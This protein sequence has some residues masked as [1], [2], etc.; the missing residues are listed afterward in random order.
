MVP[1]EV[2]AGRP[3][4]QM[5]LNHQPHRQVL[6]VSGILTKRLGQ[7]RKVRVKITAAVAAAVLAVRDLQLDPAVAD[8]VPVVVQ[9][10]PVLLDPTG[11]PTAGRTGPRGTIPAAPANM[12]AHLRRNLIASQN[13]KY[14]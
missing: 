10:T 14:G 7:V 8:Q 5:I 6:N 3:I 2:P 1:P 4:A 11:R 12:N 9:T 13:R